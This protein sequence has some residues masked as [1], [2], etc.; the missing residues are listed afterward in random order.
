MVFP[1]CLFTNLICPLSGGVKNWNERPTT[2]SMRTSF[3][4]GGGSFST[5]L[6]LIG[7]VAKVSLSSLSR[8]NRPIT[9]SDICLF[10]LTP[11]SKVNTRLWLLSLNNPW[12]L[13]LIKKWKFLFEG[14]TAIGITAFNRYS[15]NLF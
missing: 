14:E 12:I 10:N 13:G 5:H 7:H 3:D 15:K 1:S 8:N 4:M 11:L 6:L 9:R 2:F